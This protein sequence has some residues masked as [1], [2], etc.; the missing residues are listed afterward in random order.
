MEGA[1][2][3]SSGVHLEMKV[4]AHQFEGQITQEVQMAIT[5][6]RCSY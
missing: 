6:R 2:Q 1:G 3:R 5:I 4:G